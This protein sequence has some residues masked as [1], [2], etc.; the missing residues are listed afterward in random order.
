MF[1]A[2]IYCVCNNQIDIY[3]FSDYLDEIKNEVLAAQH[4]L[5]F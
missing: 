5:S 4:D 1:G 3:V 2:G